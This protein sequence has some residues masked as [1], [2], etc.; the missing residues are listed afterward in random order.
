MSALDDYF[1]DMGPYAPDPDPFEFEA[2][3]LRTTEKAVLYEI[4]RDVKVQL[5][6]PKKL[7]LAETVARKTGEEDVV[8]VPQWFA[9]QEGID[10]L[11]HG[12]GPR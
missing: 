6:V 10:D 1:D 7:L 12:G 5:W 2:L 11:V 9:E 3:V 8:F 4:G